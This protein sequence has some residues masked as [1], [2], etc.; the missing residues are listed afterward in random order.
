MGWNRASSVSARAGRTIMS[1][2]VL[3]CRTWPLT[4]RVSRS[5]SSSAR[6][7][8]STRVSHGPAG[9]NVG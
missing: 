5:G 6:S 9:V 3:S 4:D 2:T 1:A 7:A 8:A